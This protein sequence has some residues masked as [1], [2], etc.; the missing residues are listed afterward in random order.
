MDL[1]R[2]GTPKP[3]LRLSN[4]FA[5]E[6][7]AGLRQVAE[8][9]PTLWERIERREPNAYLTLLYWDSE[10]FH[11][12][13]RKRRQMEGEVQKDYKAILTEMLLKHP[14]NISPM[15]RPIMW[16]CSTGRFFIKDRPT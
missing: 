16:P 7:I 3:R 9:D 1:Y 12:S 14:E 15:K 8:V 11:R 4:Y 10:M 5:S 13:T 2:V 6:S